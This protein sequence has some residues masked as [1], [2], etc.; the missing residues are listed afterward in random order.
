MAVFEERRTCRLLRE[1]QPLRLDAAE[2]LRVG[3]MNRDEGCPLCRTVLVKAATPFGK[4]REDALLRLVVAQTR[5][6][7]IVPHD[8]HIVRTRIVRRARNAAREV[9]ARE[10]RVDDERL[11]I[12]QIDAHAH[13]QPRIFFE[14]FLS[15]LFVHA[16]LPF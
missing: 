9:G 10:R 11:I 6:P 14:K 7:F 5:E 1:R 13:D 15:V 16:L 12:L 2:D 8:R 4:L 3:S